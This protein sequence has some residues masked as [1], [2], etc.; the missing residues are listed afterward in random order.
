VSVLGRCGAPAVPSLTAA[1][2]ARQPVTV[3]VAAASA[4]AQTG[5]AAAA[6]AVPLCQCLESPD[7]TLRWHASRALGTLGRP[8]VAP[9]LGLLH[10]SSDPGLARA[11]VSALG[12]L[13]PEARE[14][15]EAITKV[16]A[17]GADGLPLACET[18][19]IRITGDAPARLPRLTSALGDPDASVRQAAL[20]HLG[21][22]RDTARS[23]APGI[24]ACLSDTS[25]DVRGTAA[26][27]LARVGADGPA[28]VAGLTARLQD[29]SLEV[30]ALTAMA[31]S[32]HGPAAA[33]ALPALERMQSGGD[34]RLAAVAQAA[35][36]VISGAVPGSGRPAAGGPPSEASS[37]KA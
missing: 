5:P 2:D 18:A 16:G 4:L 37:G 8:A 11:V 30:R 29:P 20:G 6:A 33:S 32:A 9:L 36:A 3:R 24:V 28:V 1:L 34:V 17:S 31:L 22:L 27:A 12:S 23:A 10:S 14:A 35:M 25:P 15:V 13:G 26:L 21:E 19:L 7:E